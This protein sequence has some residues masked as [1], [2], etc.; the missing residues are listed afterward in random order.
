MFFNRLKTVGQQAIVGAFKQTSQILFP[1]CCAYC[2]KILAERAVFC[3]DCYALI[4]PIV[5]KPV[6]LTS[7]YTMSVLAIADYQD[8]IRNL[9]LAKNWSDIIASK[10]LGELI[11]Q[12][13]NYKYMP[14]DYIVP[15]PLHWTRY[16]WRGFNQ[17]EEIANVL[18]RYRT[19][20]VVPLVKRSKKT[21]FQATLSAADR[22]G[23]VKEA[24]S[25]TTNDLEQYRGKHIIIVD[26]LMT[27]G[28]TLIATAKVLTTVAPA[29]ITAIVPCRVCGK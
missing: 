1:T 15:V 22:A 7:K 20:P 27:T 24:F 2:K 28:S 10:Q 17:A 16:A 25:L 18:G 12:L 8:P 23:N 9:I 26:D 4:R 11:W 6:Q 19:I 5:S 21:R 14:A 13:T 29:T 3:G